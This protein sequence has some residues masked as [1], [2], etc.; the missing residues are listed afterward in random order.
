MSFVFTR[1]IYHGL[2]KKTLTLLVLE[3][4]N[5]LEKNV[6]TCFLVG[7]KKYKFT[8]I[9][10][11]IG[12]VEGN[13]KR[14]VTMN[15]PPENGTCFAKP[16][17]GPPLEP[18]FRLH[19]KGFKDLEEPLRYEFFYSKGEGSEDVTLGSGPEASRSEVVFPSGL[20]KNDN[21]LTLRAK[22]SD[23]LGASSMVLFESAIQV[24]HG[25]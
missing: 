2:F 18:K 24:I 20:K 9:G 15:E 3:I 17:K 1:N 4:D 25:A 11:I 7:C 22:V 8:L 23:S 14:E 12:G 21:N 6:F 19:C 13:A 10:W 5:L 16:S